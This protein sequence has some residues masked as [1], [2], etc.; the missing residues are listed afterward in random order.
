MDGN[1]QVGLSEYKARQVIDLPTIRMQV[2]EHRVIEKTCRRC[3]RQ[4]TGDFPKG[5]V[6]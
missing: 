4:N 6:Q 2:T 5:L 1:S 3:K